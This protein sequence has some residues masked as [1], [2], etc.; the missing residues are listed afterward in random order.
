MTEL[1]NM[2][3]KQT[4]FDDFR[5]K[6][7]DYKIVYLTHYGSIL[8]GTNSESSDIDIKGIFIPT[9]N[10]VILKLDPDHYTKNTN[11]SKKED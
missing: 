7:P 3:L 8:Y 6:Y 5:T 10:D 11:N 2:Q 1:K 4:I 9:M